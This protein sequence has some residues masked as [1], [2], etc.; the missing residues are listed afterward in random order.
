MQIS[1]EYLDAAGVARRAYFRR[2][3]TFIPSP[4]GTH[5][6]HDEMKSKV[7]DAECRESSRWNGDNPHCVWHFATVAELAEDLREFKRRYG[8]RSIPFTGNWVG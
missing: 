4:R 5:R 7:L 8:G 3:A 1:Q 2:E 6:L